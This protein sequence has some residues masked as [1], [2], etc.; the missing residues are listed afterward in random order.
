MMVVCDN[1]SNGSPSIE[2]VSE[3]N[4]QG[5]RIAKSHFCLR[6]SRTKMCSSPSIEDPQY[7]IKSSQVKVVQ[8]SDVLYMLDISTAQWASPFD[9]SRVV[10]ADLLTSG[11]RCNFKMHDTRHI[12]FSIIR[13]S[14]LSFKYFIIADE[15]TGSKSAQTPLILR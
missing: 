14:Q 7:C 4:V 15:S 11:H 3:S 5:I 9:N 2:S 1:C 12:I 8:C 13:A 10:E 6:I